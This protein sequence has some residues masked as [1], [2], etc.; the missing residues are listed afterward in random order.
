MKFTGLS[1]ISERTVG[2]AYRSDPHLGDA[3]VV[4]ILL[5]ECAQLCQ[6]LGGIGNQI[7]IAN[8]VVI[9]AE[10]LPVFP[11]AFDNPFPVQGSNQKIR[12]AIPAEGSNPPLFSE[13]ES[14]VA[15]VTNNVDNQRVGNCFFDALQEKQMSLRTVGPALHALVP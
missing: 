2:L 12:S 10:F 13:G 9:S 11:P 4:Q 5:Q 3:G 15:A 8:L 7:F 1:L 14:D 6:R